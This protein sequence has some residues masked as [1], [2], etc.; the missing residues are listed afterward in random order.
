MVCSQ[1]SGT[2]ELILCFVKLLN[3]S[4]ANESKLTLQKVTCR[5]KQNELIYLQV[6]K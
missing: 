2:V 4:G 3:A 5:L 1:K 6:H